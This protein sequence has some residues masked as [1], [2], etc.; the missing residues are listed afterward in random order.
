MEYLQPGSIINHRAFF[1]EDLMYV[2]IKCN[3][4]VT[5]LKI[6]RETV[7]EVKNEHASFNYYL[8]KYQHKILKSNKSFY[9]DYIKS[10]TRRE[11]DERFQRN[12]ILKNIVFQRIVEIR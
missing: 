5:L 11:E 4:H 7:D 1:L 2:D 3:T 8:S 6:S 10:L 9:I 12:N